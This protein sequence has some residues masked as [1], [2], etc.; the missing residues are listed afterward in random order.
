MDPAPQLQRDARVCREVGLQRYDI[1]GL[2]MGSV[3]G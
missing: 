1:Q 2:L 3:K